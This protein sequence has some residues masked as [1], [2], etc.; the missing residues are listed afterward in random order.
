MIGL[1]R[2]LIRFAPLSA[3]PL[4][5]SP[6]SASPLSSA[7][8]PK[9]N[10]RFLTTSAATG[11]PDFSQMSYTQ[12]QALIDSLLKEQK[13]A[14][15]KPSYVPT[16]LPQLVAAGLLRIAITKIGSLRYFG[17]V[18]FYLST[19]INKLSEG[20]HSKFLSYFE[21]FQTE[22]TSIVK[23]IPTFI[24]VNSLVDDTGNIKETSEESITTIVVSSIKD[25]YT[26]TYNNYT[27]SPGL[28]KTE[29]I[30]F[31]IITIA[32]NLY[33]CSINPELSEEDKNKCLQKMKD[34]VASLSENET[35]INQIADT[36]IESLNPDSSTRL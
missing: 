19:V 7:L 35:K 12:R 27:E 23:E 32:Y 25:S 36:V 20:L 5:A 15:D 1:R 6:L 4:S 3:S 16:P 33:L 21:S 2:A 22:H 34:F 30:A 17:P 26:E 8:L 28:L 11:R 13:S 10:A 18:G 29:T 24:D 9:G 14:L 31:I